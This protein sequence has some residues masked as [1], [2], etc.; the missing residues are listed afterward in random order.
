MQG[1]STLP[2]AS[3]STGA[4]EDRKPTLAEMEQSSRTTSAHPWVGESGEKKERVGQVPVYAH[5]GAPGLPGAW[6]RPRWDRVGI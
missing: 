6:T 5:E 3:T 1:N 4:G 2:S